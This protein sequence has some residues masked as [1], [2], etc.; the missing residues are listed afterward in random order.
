[1]AYNIRWRRAVMVSVFCHIFLFAAV[2]YLS[3]QLLTT[4]VV[5]EQYVELELMNES[6]AEQPMAS[7]PNSPSPS[8]VDSSEPTRLPEKMK[9]SS[10]LT[11]VAGKETPSVVTTG[12]L[13]AIS[14]SH[15]TNP[16]SSPQSGNT[17][18]ATNS[19]SNVGTSGT[20]SGVISP[21]ILSKIPP[22]YPEAARRAGR[23]GTVV[24]KIQILE[25]GHGEN[26]SVVS[27]SGSDILDDA[28][29]A[30]IG[31]WH[32]VP[33]KNKENGQAIA[34]YTTIPISFRLKE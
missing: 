28:A 8:L 5:Q 22:A 32:F 20:S 4:P 19:T 33:A 10:P 34:C 25:N 12:D 21:R 31:Q 29:I 17:G 30:T 15:E 23:E 14:S 1:M 16:A 27:S 24:L 9:Q 2:G 6:Q 18:S 7:T 13:A 26:I 3:A 11:P